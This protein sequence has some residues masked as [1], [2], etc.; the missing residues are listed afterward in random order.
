MA[1]TDIQLVQAEP[2]HSVD[3]MAEI[4]A[5]IAA[6]DREYERLREMVVTGLASGLLWQAVVSSVTRRTVAI[7]DAQQLLPFD[8]FE[9]LVEPIHQ[10]NVTRRRRPLP[11]S[12][13]KN[14]FAAVRWR[15]SWPQQD[16]ALSKSRLPPAITS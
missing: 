7:A 12:T 13:M 2:E 6:L 4:K 1:S 16:H 15:L 11:K 14:V 9:A 5:Q 3:R 8:L 10:T